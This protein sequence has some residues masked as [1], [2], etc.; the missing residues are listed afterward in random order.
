MARTRNKEAR[1][2]RIVRGHA[3]SRLSIRA[4][5]DQRGV[6]EPAFYWWRRE[7]ARRDAVPPAVIG[8]PNPAI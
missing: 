3:K 4:Y 7:L 2:R 8:R 6:K 5:C 1:W